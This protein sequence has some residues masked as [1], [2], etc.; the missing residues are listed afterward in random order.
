MASRIGKAEMQITQIPKENTYTIV[1]MFDTEIVNETNIILHVI[2]PLEIIKIIDIFEE[3]TENM[4]TNYKSI[5]M[6]EV[7]LLKSKIGS[8]IPSGRRKERGLINFIGSAEKWLFGIMDDEDRQSVINHLEITDSNNHNI[9]KTVNQQISIN[10]NFND[11]LNVLRNSILDDRKEISLGLNR[12]ETQN[13]EIRDRLMFNEQILKL[14]FLESKINDILDS[15]ASAKY[16][17]FHPSLLS[18]EEIDEYKIDFYKL[19]LIKMGILLYK[20]DYLILTIKIPRNYLKTIV[21]LIIPTPN[22]SFY[23]INAKEEMFVN[24]RNKMYKFENDRELKE[25]KMSK[26]CIF[27]NNCELIVNNK[28]SIQSLNDETILIKNAK[29][30]EMSTN[31]NELNKIELNAN[32]IVT[33]SNCEIFIED[34]KFYNKKDKYIEKY[35]NFVELRKDNFTK[36]I[37]FKDIIISNVR[38]IEKIE[39]L[40]YNQIVSY[41]LIVVLGVII[42]VAMIA[43]C[44]LHKKTSIKVKINET[45]RENRLTKGGGVTYPYP[46]QSYATAIS[47]EEVL[48]NYNK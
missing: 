11:T 2:Q 36:Q 7:K 14:K 37:S 8:I 6:S 45:I 20:N 4:N 39:E 41:S 18:T 40:K 47:V 42:F 12:I 19:K 34:S 22:L 26:H 9:I 15:I 25:L 48:K 10:N 1:K 38:N 29:N 24:L 30:L 43:M 31:C 27:Q 21:N 5:L 44:Y 3:N 46:N 13:T 17:I 16:N 35:V 33:F 23:E 28:T 32:N